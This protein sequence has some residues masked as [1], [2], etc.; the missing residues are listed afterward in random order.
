MMMT[1]K[2]LT[3]AAAICAAN[4]AVASEFPIGLMHALTGPVGFVGTTMANGAILGAEVINK[5]KL[6]GDNTIKMVVADT[7]SDRNQA[8]TLVA[9]L[10][11][12]DNV[13]MILGPTSSIESL[14]AAPVANE[15]EIVL[16]TPALSSDI[17]KAGPWAFKAMVSTDAYMRPVSAYVLEKMKPKKVAIIFDRQNDST[18]TQKNSFKDAITKGGIEV[19]SEH[20]I[21]GTD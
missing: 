19:V 20:G 8:M 18:V 13:L 12:S 17:F 7:A 3:I 5:K 10:A 4:T 9:K 6:L 14:A 2:R 11:T 15:K 21:L 16:Y 1:L